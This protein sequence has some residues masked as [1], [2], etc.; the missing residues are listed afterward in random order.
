[1]A[2]DSR[3]SCYLSLDA[4]DDAD[5]RVCMATFTAE[6]AAAWQSLIDTVNVGAPR[7]G[8]FVRVTGGRKWRGV[9]GRV[10]RHMRSKYD[11]TSRY[12]NDA[13]ATL[14]DARGREGFVVFI[15][16]DMRATVCPP[17]GKGVWVK[18][19][20]CEVIA[21]PDYDSIG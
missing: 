7:V 11:R 16:P 1:M 18:A 2:S 15:E 20:Q 12:L 6:N 17:G 4:K 5:Y 19:E 8:T 10:T 21:V 14:R 3:P 9:E 13:Q